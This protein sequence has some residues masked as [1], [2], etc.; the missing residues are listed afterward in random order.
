[1]NKT[2]LHFL[3]S[4]LFILIGAILFSSCAT[5]TNI[6]YLRDIPKS[7]EDRPVQEVARGV[8]SFESIRIEPYDLL[9]VSI[10]T[11]DPQVNAVFNQTSEGIG[12]TASNSGILVDEQGRVVLP[13]IGKVKVA[14]LTTA[15]ARDTIN[16]IANIYLK[17]PIV[18]VRLA[19]FKITVIGEVMKPAQYIIPD[20]RVNFIEAIGLAGDLTVHG[21][22]DNIMLIRHNLDQKKYVRINMADSRFTN[23]K[24]FYLKQGDI[25]YVEPTRLKSTLV[26]PKIRDLAVLSSVVS[27]SAFLIAFIKK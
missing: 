2:K 24:Y 3:P 20:E 6:T 26:N 19:N 13:I 23:S 27:V 4:I 12:S 22:R 9:Q 10:H 17:D 18:N 8:D 21:K 25:L 16:A 11:L 5:Y 7:A 1:M 15:Q 14:G